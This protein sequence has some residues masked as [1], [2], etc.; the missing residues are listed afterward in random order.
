MVK[1]GQNYNDVTYA[2][3]CIS[4]RIS[5][6]L[7]QSSV[8][9][10]HTVH[11]FLSVTS[12]QWTWMTQP[13]TYPTYRRS[14]HACSCCS[15]TSAALGIQQ[16][17]VFLYDVRT[18]HRFRK[19][20]RHKFPG[21]LMACSKDEN[22]F[23]IRDKVL[24]NRFNSRQ[25]KNMPKTWT[26]EKPH[27]TGARPETSLKHSL[28]RLARQTGVPASAAQTA[29]KL[30]HLH[31]CKTTEVHTRYDTSRE[32]R[33]YFASC[34]SSQNSSRDRWEETHS[35]SVLFSD[36]QSFISYQNICEISE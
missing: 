7:G 13:A 12:Q 25:E 23:Q 11:H 1:T 29:T 15:Q 26:V 17:R 32:A 36:K 2:R 24:G 8:Y 4:A 9:F 33:V 16:H 10:T 28:V 5:S 31:P 3:R 22:N 14:C 30:L 35:T 20:C 21:F 34:T 27:E 19:K 6:E 18:K